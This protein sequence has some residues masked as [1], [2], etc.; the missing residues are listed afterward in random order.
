[1]FMQLCHGA[2]ELPEA[3]GWRPDILHCHDWHTSL[4]PALLRGTDEAPASLAAT[5]CIL[6]LHNIGYQGV[7]S[8]GVLAANGFGT[9]E[10]LV[11]DEERAHGSVV[12]LKLGIR[13]ADA[14]TTVSPTYA[15]EIQTPEY[16]MALEGLL[17][18]RREHLSGIL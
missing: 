17:R 15:R 1:R 16:G 5:P 7:Y 2:L 3:L 12:F 13:F 8:S 9:L 11:A 6:T 18:E 14:V 10:K 4:V